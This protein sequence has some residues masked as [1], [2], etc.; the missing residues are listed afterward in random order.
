MIIE[1][2]NSDGASVAFTISSQ[3]RLSIDPVSG[4]AIC[5]FLFDDVE[6]AKRFLRTCLAALGES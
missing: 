4:G 5:S 6:E 1:E 3:P 2:V